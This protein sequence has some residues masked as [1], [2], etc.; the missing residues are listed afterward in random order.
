M[1]KRVLSLFVITAAAAGFLTVSP[2]AADENWNTPE[3][4][5]SDDYSEVKAVRT[6]EGDETV[7]ETETAKTTSEVTKEPGCEEAGEMTYTAVFE[8]SAFETQTEVVSIDPKG[9]APGQPV[10]ENEVPAGC[11]D[12]SYDEVIYCETC[13]E[14]L[15]RRTVPVGGSGHSAG[16]PVIENKTAPTCSSDGYYDEVVYCETCGEELSRREVPVGGGSGDHVWGEWVVTKEPTATQTG[17][18]TRTCTLNPAHTETET[19]PATGKKES[20]AGK[21]D[22]NAGNKDRKRSVSPAT[23]DDSG[24]M[25]WV[26]LLL[27]AAGSAGAAFS[28]R[29]N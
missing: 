23:G 29:K 18:R 26:L 22:S 7:S 17:V 21:T 4:E 5:W 1:M 8:N 28:L 24:L 6:L 16:E 2:V 13:G 10:T 19:I 9:H 25:L 27:A 20:S 12:G 14:E 11:V 3:Y 15:E